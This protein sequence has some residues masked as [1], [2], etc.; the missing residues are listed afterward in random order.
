MSHEAGLPRRF[1]RLLPPA[2]TL[3]ACLGASQP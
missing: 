2:V 3:A 1:A